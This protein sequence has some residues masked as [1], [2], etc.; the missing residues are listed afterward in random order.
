MNYL[1]SNVADYTVTERAKRI[2]DGVVEGFVT[3]KTSDVVTPFELALKQV[4]QLPTRAGNVLVPGAGIGTYILALLREGFKPEQITAVEL[5]PAYSRLGY[6]IFSRF[7]IHYVT[8]DFTTWQTTMQFDVIIGNP[9]YQNG[10]NS[11]FYVRFLKCA[12]ELLKEGGYLS[13]LAPTK[14]CL[15]S[16]KAQKPLKELGWNKLTLGM[17]KWFPQQQQTISLYEAIKCCDPEKLEVVCEGFTG[18][19]PFGTVFPVNNANPLAISIVSKFF[20]Y[21]EKLPFQRLKQAPSGNYIYVSRMVRRYS[22]NKPKGGPLGFQPFVNT[23]GTSFDGGFLECSKKDTAAY[24]EL[25]TNSP[26]YRFVN[27]HV[28]RAAFVPPLFWSQTP[29]LGIGNEFEV[30]CALLDLTAEESEYI[31]QWSEVN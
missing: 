24:V 17:E 22:P 16:S 7:G 12:N 9:P 2:Y 28:F 31:T 10:K 19:Y 27:A 1:Q 15:P 26:I 20:R 5:D 8:A 23:N 18:E 29:N 14:G 4:R 11:D 3:D 30:M 13:F 25:L 6:G 21:P